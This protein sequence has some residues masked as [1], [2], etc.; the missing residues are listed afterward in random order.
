[1]SGT[2]GQD[3]A[4]RVPENF[5]ILEKVGIPENSEEPV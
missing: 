5:G 1:M 4:G 2:R 3:E